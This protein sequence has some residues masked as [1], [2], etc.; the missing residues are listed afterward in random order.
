MRIVILNVAIT[1][2]GMIEGP[3]GEIDWCLTDAD[4][5]MTAFL[6]R[7]DTIVMGRKSYEQFIALSPDLWSDKRKYVFSRSLQ[8]VAP[9]FEKVEDTPSDFINNLRAQ[10]GGDV[11]LFGGAILTQA[12]LEAGLL[13]ELLLAIHPVV[14]GGGKPMFPS[15]Q[16]LP[17]ELISSRA[18]PSGLIQAAYR[19]KTPVP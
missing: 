1:L 15:A 10:P 2:D 12:F 5:G 3:S 8:T 18:W 4:Y 9:G 6:Q 17:L 16:R 19:L 7:I 11:W 14:L 13:N